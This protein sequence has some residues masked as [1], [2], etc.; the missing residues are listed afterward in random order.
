MVNTPSIPL[1]L[2]LV[3]GVIAAVYAAVLIGRINKLPAGNE[4]MQGI[5]SAIQE[6]AM[7]YLGRQYRTVEIRKGSG[8]LLFLLQRTNTHR[9]IFRDIRGNLFTLGTLAADQARRCKRAVRFVAVVVNR[10]TLH[11]LRHDIRIQR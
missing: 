10:D 3:A 6:G 4:K 1:I 2:G 7:A 5:A 8:V 9:R 11:S